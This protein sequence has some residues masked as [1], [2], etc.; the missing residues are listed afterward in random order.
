MVFQF[1]D[2]LFPLILFVGLIILYYKIFY[3]WDFIGPFTNYFSSFNRKQSI[4][5]YI[6]EVSKS[7]VDNKQQMFFES[8][9]FIGIL[10]IIYLVATKTVLFVAVASGSMRPLFDQ[11]DLVLVQDIEHSYK[12]GDVIFFNN[13][14]TLVPYTHRIA[15]ITENG[16]IRTAGDA[17]GVMDYWELDKKDIHGKVVLLNGKAFVIPKYGEFFLVSAG[18]ESAGPFKNLNDY[19]LFFQVVKT[20]GY[21]IV[22]FSLLIYIVMTIRKTKT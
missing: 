2:I 7:K 17:I 20:Y 15:K 9:I 5:N 22:V 13:P 19:V 4:N 12:Q 11:N 6:K 1:K 10:I 21:V 14:D 8:L 3:S 16:K 18:Q